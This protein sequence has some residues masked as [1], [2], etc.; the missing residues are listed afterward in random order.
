MISVPP[1]SNAV[2]DSSDSKCSPKVTLV[3]GL[4][5]TFL[6]IV[7]GADEEADVTWT[8]TRATGSSLVLEV[9]LAATSG[10]D[11]VRETDVERFSITANYAEHH[12]QTLTCTATNSVGSATH[13]ITVNV[14]GK[15]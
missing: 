12:D 3:D 8:L 6:C 1:G 13:S 10:V 4:T 11:C 7:T 14:L 9:D 5:Y 2:I 15:Q